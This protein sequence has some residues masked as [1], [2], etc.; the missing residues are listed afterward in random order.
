TFTDATKEITFKTSYKDPERSGF[1]SD[2]HDLLSSRL[3]LS[4][5]DYDRGFDL[6]EGFHRNTIKLGPEYV[7]GM[8]DEGE[9]T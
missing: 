5:D 6:E 9:V 3:I 4:E 1:S 8:D 2:G 7:T